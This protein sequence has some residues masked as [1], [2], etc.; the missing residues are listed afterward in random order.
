MDNIKK[1]FSEDSRCGVICGKENR[2]NCKE[3]KSKLLLHINSL[4]SKLS[5][6]EIKYKELIDNIKD[7]IFQTDKAGLWIFLTPTWTQFTGFSLEESLGRCFWE[8]THIND[9]EF[10]HKQFLA[11]VEGKKNI[12]ATKFVIVLE[13]VNIAGQK[14]IYGL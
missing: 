12:I 2:S 1:M 14:S 8:Y 13:K 11:V 6:V 10:H 3:C 7:T 9:R 4:Q 5:H